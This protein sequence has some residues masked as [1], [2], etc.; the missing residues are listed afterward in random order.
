VDS[1][2]A[3]E[4]RQ[5]VYPT[6]LDQRAAEFARTFRSDE[7]YG[8]LQFVPL[9]FRNADAMF[10]AID[11]WNRAGGDPRRASS[12]QAAQIIALLSTLFPRPEHRRAVT[13]W[14]G[15]VREEDRIFYRAYWDSQ[16]ATL[17]P[18][19]TAVQQ[20]W[21]SLAPS[22]ANYLEFVRLRRGELF[23][24]PALGAEG[25]LVTTELEVPRSAVLSPPAAHPDYAVLA[26]VHELLY[27]LVGEVIKEHVAP[28]RI[29]EMGAQRLAA[30]SALRGGAMLLERVAPARVDSYRRFYL[31]ASGRT[32]APGESLEAAFAAAFPLPPELE[33]GLR[34]AVNNALAGI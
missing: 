23:L 4:R 24:V 19:V 21:D 12:A 27:P 16:A 14:A 20:V 1:I 31:E 9:Y 10:S 33:A 30:L 28:A 22:L 17:A 15:L 25:R 7:A 3:V 5:G 2:T 26:F 32:P 8:N 34:T 18:R 29:R 13:E 6:P 11:L